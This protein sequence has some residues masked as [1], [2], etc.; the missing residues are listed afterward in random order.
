MESTLNYGPIKV[1]LVGFENGLQDSSYKMEV[2]A[3]TPWDGA[4]GNNPNVITEEEMHNALPGFV[5]P[6]GFGEMTTLDTSG[7]YPFQ[8]PYAG[9]GNDNYLRLNFRCAL[10]ADYTL[11]L[12]LWYKGPTLGS[13]SLY[14]ICYKFFPLTETADS[15]INNATVIPGLTHHQTIHLK[16]VEGDN[17]PG[18]LIVGIADIDGGGD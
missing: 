5:T 4:T 6:V 8:I 17:C 18:I 13:D 15:T 9:G 10:F 1:P 12:L 16:F 7:N 11:S 14:E 3:Y 2:K